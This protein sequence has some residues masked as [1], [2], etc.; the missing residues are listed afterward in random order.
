MSTKNNGFKEH[1]FSQDKS[2]QNMKRSRTM[3]PE[4]MAN[5]S[6]PKQRGRPRKNKIAFLPENKEVSNNSSL[7]NVLHLSDLPR[8]HS[9]LKNGQPSI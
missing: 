7:K 1:D 9:A 3:R 6:A 5:I 2:F 8:L 4:R